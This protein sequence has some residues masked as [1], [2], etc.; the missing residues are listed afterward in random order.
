M[1]FHRFEN[2]EARTRAV[3][4][5]TGQT[6]K[7]VGKYIYFAHVRKETSTGS[8]AHYH[9]N[10]YMIFILE[11]KA[12][13]LCGKD[14]RMIMPGT[15]MHVPPSAQ[16]QLKA[17]EE[18]DM[19]YLAIK[20]PTWSMVGAAVDEPLPDA[21]PVEEEVWAKHAK[22]EWPGEEKDP[23]KST[24]IFDGFGTPYYNIIDSFDA[25]A[26][27]AKTI[28]RVMGERLNFGFC[29]MPMGHEEP[30]HTSEHERFIYLVRGGLEVSVDGD[31]QQCSRD[32]VIEIPKGSKISLK[33]TE[34]PARFVSVE[35]TIELEKFVDSQGA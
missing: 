7:I 28:R 4:L 31:C 12:N 18:G 16:H 15:L 32:D 11:G 10:D 19:C 21:P 29:D 8:V 27:S 30:L 26:N 6:R 5:S 13:A 23:E 25:P 9:P 34:G 24:A 14:R 3:H 17:A 1:T 20:E 2:Y 33:V 35:S 22:G